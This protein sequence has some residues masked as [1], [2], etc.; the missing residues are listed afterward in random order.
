[1]KQKKTLA[2]L[3][4]V[5][6][7]LIAVGLVC[8]NLGKNH[9]AA[10]YQKE[11]E[12]NILLNRSDLDGLGAIEGTIYI[13]GHSSPDSDTVCSS[14]AYASLLQ[15]MGYDAVPVV[16]GKINHETEYIL[17]TAG[18]E[19][20][21]LLEDAAGQNMILVDHSDYTQS[22]QGLKEGHIISIIDHHGDGTVT[23]GNPIIYDA[24]PIGAT[25][26]IIWIRYRNYGIEPEK[27]IAL[28]LLGA[29]L[30]DTKN[31]Q[32]ETV[33]AADREAVKTL[34]D[35]AGLSDVDAFYQEMFKASLSYEGMSDEEVYL[36]DYKEY[37]AGGRKY[38]IACVNAYDEKS[39]KALLDRMEKVMP[40]KPMSNGLDMAFAQISIF[41]D[42]ISVTYL[43]PSNAAA[44]EVLEQ[45]FGQTAV[46][47]G[48]AYRLEPGISRKK[49]LVPAITD[50]L[51]SYPKE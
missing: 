20:P 11:A 48:T 26:T 23:T 37:E 45:S 42:D 50:V 1:M 49:D 19:T 24:R 34:S 31:L 30:S 36:S 18:L 16:L 6:I 47:D 51:E 13:T 3:G 27:S 39:A 33:T 10:Y 41:H 44:K 32:S 5:I 43:L 22:V 35:Q 28:A 2:V 38:G 25:A 17:K 4:C 7:L 12:R 8:Y 15:A 9:G 46:F 21:Q 14:I 40:S 29:I